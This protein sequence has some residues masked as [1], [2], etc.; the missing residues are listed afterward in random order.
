M[1]TSSC[2]PSRKVTRRKDMG[3]CYCML[4]RLR[5]KMRVRVIQSG[6]SAPS[7][8]LAQQL[9]DEGHC[10]SI[11]LVHS[12]TIP[13]EGDVVVVQNKGRQTH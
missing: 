13:V 2:F 4:T 12:G 1:E 9:L 8:H 11:W 6:K 3:C 7:P 5:S 10:V